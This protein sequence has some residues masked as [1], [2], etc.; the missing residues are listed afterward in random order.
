MPKLFFLS[1]VSIDATVLN[2]LLDC[3]YY[4][5]RVVI[6][7]HRAFISL[8]LLMLGEE[9][10]QAYEWSIA[11]TCLLLKIKEKRD[12]TGNLKVVGSDTSTAPYTTQIDNF[13]H[14]VCC[15]NCNFCSKKTEN[16]RE[17]GRGLPSFL[18]NEKELS[19]FGAQSDSL[20]S[21]S[22]K[23]KLFSITSND[24]IEFKVL[25]KLGI[26]GASNSIVFGRKLILYIGLNGQ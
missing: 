7:H 20:D 11:L 19:H 17:R 12:Q 10:I 26:C 14:I 15:Q 1:W 23:K 6:Y 22:I 9:E 5:S 2:G 16:K 4:D 25:R 18:K 3:L 13:F 8:T 21:K 24:S